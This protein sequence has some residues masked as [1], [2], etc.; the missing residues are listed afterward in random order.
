M[1]P[2]IKGFIRNT[3]I[4]WE[5]RIA[6]EIFLPGC[7]FR[8]PYCHSP[9]LVVS[10]NTLEAIPFYAVREYLKENRDWV[11]SII[12]SGGEPT[13][14]AEIDSLASE[15]KSIDVAVKL[16]TNGSNPDKLASLIDS[17]L[18]DFVSVDIKAPL[19][20]KYNIAAG[21]EVDVSLISDSISII[22]NSDIAYEFRTTA[23]SVFT[24]EEDI[25][26]IAET[27]AGAKLYVL[28]E[29]VPG[30][31]LSSSLN[32]YKSF[33]RDELKKIAEKASIHVEECFLRGE[34][35]SKPKIMNATPPKPEFGKE[36]Q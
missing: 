7:N 33:S 21:I 28:Q 1:L 4:D 18:I 12:I 9:H 5:G 13:I 29:F 27:I 24:S 25:L 22:K 2:P 36:N 3:L 14:H 34:V 8:C 11:D 31:C 30:N 32:S 19:N 35:H 6:S 26:K 16:D 17:R 15:L 23:C 10:P 20:E